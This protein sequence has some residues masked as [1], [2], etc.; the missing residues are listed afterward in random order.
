MCGLLLWCYNRCFILLS[1]ATI[2]PLHRDISITRGR[3]TQ[4]AVVWATNTQTIGS[5]HRR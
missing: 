3:Q 1:R 4:G 5:S 2:V